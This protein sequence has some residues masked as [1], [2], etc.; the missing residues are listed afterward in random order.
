MVIL[1]ELILGL[2]TKGGDSVYKAK[3]Q[4]K[5]QEGWYHKFV[6]GGVFI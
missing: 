1:A 2:W 5:F 6:K 4:K 3:W